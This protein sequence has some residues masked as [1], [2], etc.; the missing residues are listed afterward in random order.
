MSKSAQSITSI[1]TPDG[2]NIWLSELI[3][4][5][6]NIEFVQEVLAQLLSI[7]VIEREFDRTD[8][9]FVQQPVG[10]LPSIKAIKQEL[11]GINGI[12]VEFVQQAVAQLPSIGAIERELQGFDGGDV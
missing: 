9:G 4:T 8:V 2:Y 11:P 5:W 12:D 3:H 10:Q 6:T 7:E 1:D